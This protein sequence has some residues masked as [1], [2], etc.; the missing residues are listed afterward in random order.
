MP[1]ERDRYIPNY[2]QLHFQKKEAAN[3][4]CEFCGRM[5]RKVGENWSEFFDRVGWQ[6][7]QE[8]KWGRRTLTVAHLNQKPEDNADE[9]LKA[10][11][12]PCHLKHDAKFRVQNAYAKRERRGQLNLLNPQP[13]SRVVALVIVNS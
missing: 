4:T 8:E 5:C 11:C 13:L 12:A 7:A 6:F 9:N 3:W 2:E 10:L 1:I